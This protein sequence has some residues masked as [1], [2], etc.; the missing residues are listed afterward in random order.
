MNSASSDGMPSRTATPLY[1]PSLSPAMSHTYVNQYA[2]S[3]YHLDRDQQTPQLPYSYDID[4]GY[5]DYSAQP[6]YRQNTG[7]SSNVFTYEYVH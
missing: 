3:E 1:Q 5:D 4:S 7:C 6:Q 2:G